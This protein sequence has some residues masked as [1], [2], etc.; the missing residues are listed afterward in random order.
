[1]KD[2]KEKILNVIK[3]KFDNKR[4]SFPKE[5]IDFEIE[6]E[7]KEI[8][9]KMSNSIL[10][11]NM[12]DNAVCFEGWAFALHVHYEN[13]KYGIK[14]AFQ[15]NLNEQI[16]K[17][18]KDPKTGKYSFC[19]ENKG[20]INRF[21]YRALRFSEQYE[22]FSLSKDISKYVESFKEYIY[23]DRLSFVNNLPS[24]NNEKNDKNTEAYKITENFIESIFENNQFKATSWSE[25]VSDDG[26]FYR[27]LPVGLFE[28]KDDKKKRVFTG[29]KSAIDLW[30][31]KD[32]TLNI[33]E[34]KYD[35]KMIGI[36]TEIFFYCNFVKDM[37]CKAM[38]TFKCNMDV[39]SGRG[40]KKLRSGRF[41]KINGYML[42]DKDN[43]HPLID[44]E[45]IDE[46]NKITK[47]NDNDNKCTINYDKI[48]YKVDNILCNV[49]ILKK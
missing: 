9:M 33:F 10:N 24:D 43:L 17:K 45:L 31:C 41:T 22:W 42:C 19:G 37:Y 2:D 6:E 16:E 49:T 8:V 48:L 36:I 47:R 20:H 29:G 32:D 12:Q 18:C 13:K 1:M 44:K 46:M 30:S 15:E 14:L 39:K 5:S 34:L 38:K 27:Q 40:F 35:N 25:S 26:S 3:E 21:L 28:G 11:T 23:N 7:S 4:I